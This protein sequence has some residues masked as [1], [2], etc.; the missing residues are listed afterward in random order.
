[1]G[2]VTQKA[3]LFS[4]TIEGN[5]AFGQAEHEITEDDVKKAVNISQAQEFN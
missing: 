5:I 3:V 2:Y 1:M 4:D